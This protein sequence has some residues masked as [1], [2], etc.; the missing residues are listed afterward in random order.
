MNDCQHELVNLESGQ[1]QHC[2]RQVRPALLDRLAK[3]E[4]SV[5]ELLVAVAQ[6]PKSRKA[7][8]A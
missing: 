4:K 5:D 7:E 1:C 8:E 6:G 2:G 3:L